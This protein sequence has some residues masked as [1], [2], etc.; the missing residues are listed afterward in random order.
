M[1]MVIRLRLALFLALLM[2]VTPQ[3]PLTSL[4][5]VQASP[6]ENGTTSPLEILSLAAG[7][8]SEPA[9]VGD[10]DGNFHIFWIANQTDAMY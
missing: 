3:T 9:I 6:E 8:L 1:M 7:S 4:E 5:S 10:D 2:L